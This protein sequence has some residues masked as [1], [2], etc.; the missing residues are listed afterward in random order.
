[1]N[2]YKEEYWLSY[3]VELSPVVS[4]KSISIKEEA[5]VVIGLI[6]RSNR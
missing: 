3:P 1:L 2:R 6:N 5:P 4:A